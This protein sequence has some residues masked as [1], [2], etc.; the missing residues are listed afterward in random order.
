MEN[1]KLPAYPLPLVRNAEGEVKDASDWEGSN[2]GFTKLELASLM[3]AQGF[4]ARVGIAN[5]PGEIST[6]AHLSTELAKA[7]IAEAN[8]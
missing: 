8:K 5:S 1:I 4:V 3:I 6:I 2:V 7:V